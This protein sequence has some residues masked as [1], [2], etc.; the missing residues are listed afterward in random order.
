MS[1]DQVAEAELVVNQKIRDSVRMYPTLYS[2]I[3]D[4]DLKQVSRTV[5]LIME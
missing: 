1:K 2:S 5:Y 4:P 3:D